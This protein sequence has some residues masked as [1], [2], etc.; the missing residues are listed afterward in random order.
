MVSAREQTSCRIRTCIGCGAKAQ[1]E[2][3]VRV[4]RGA[5]GTIA[6]DRTGRGDGR[7]AYVCSLKCFDKAC[8]NGRL[9]RSLRLKVDAETQRLI[10][11]DIS[12]LFDETSR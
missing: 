5:D 4:G 9:A 1:K 6:V 11:E 10:R 12:S 3:L 8:S 2:F 7:G